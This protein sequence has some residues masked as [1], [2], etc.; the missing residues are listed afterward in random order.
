M[1]LNF[2]FFPSFVRYDECCTFARGSL[3]KS[4]YV[5]AFCGALK[6]IS[7]DFRNNALPEINGSLCYS[8]FV[9]SF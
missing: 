9:F 8:F 7:C 2:V 4:A 6:L 3:T 1:F 5:N